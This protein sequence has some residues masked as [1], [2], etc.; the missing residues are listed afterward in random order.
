MKDRR[1]KFLLTGTLGV[2]QG[3]CMHSQ[4]LHAFTGTACIHRYCMHSQ[5]LHA[6]TGTACIHRYCMHSQVLHAFTG[7]VGT[8]YRVSKYTSAM[9]IV[10]QLDKSLKFKPIRGDKF[11]LHCTI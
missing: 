8:L 9:S 3:Y 6:F 5:V 1:M 7:T 10:S 2:S 4:V 11:T